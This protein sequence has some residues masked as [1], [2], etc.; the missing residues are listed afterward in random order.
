MGNGTRSSTVA[1]ARSEPE[2]GQMTTT[3]ID[4]LRQSLRSII[5]AARRVQ[6]ETAADIYSDA[7]ECSESIE[8]LNSA[9]GELQQATD[10]GSR[11]LD[12]L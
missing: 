3:K 11:L 2:T 1:T 5:G 4:A 9:L 6:D 12:A 10:E 8:N 7:P